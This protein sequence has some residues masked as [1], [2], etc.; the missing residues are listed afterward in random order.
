MSEGK[1]TVLL[2]GPLD[3]LLHAERR[4]AGPHDVENVE[5]AVAIAP[6]EHTG[7]EIRIGASHLLARGEIPEAAET[8]L[9]EDRA[10]IDELAFEPG[11]LEQPSLGSDRPISVTE[12]AIGKGA[13]SFKE[14][15]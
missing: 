11:R 12:L 14:A 1:L 10:E 3:E 5:D 2:C 15:S 13:S 7:R 6:E 8:D 4:H 9:R